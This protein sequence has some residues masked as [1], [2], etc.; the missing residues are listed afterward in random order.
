MNHCKE[1]KI[2]ALRSLGFR[3]TT[4]NEGSV[5]VERVASGK[6][7]WSGRFYNG[8]NLVPR[9]VHAWFWDGAPGSG[10]DA[11]LNEDETGVLFEVAK[12][13]RTGRSVYGPLDLASDRR[14]M[15]LEALEEARDLAVYIAASIMKLRRTREER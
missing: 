2:W 13:L 3:V 10:E 12:G 4:P 8:R 5:F 6:P 9:V 14:D 11:S 7:V 15:E 1:S